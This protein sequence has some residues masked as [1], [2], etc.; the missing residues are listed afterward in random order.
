MK[1]FKWRSGYRPCPHPGSAPRRPRCP[2]PPRRPRCP[3]PRNK[4]A[5]RQP[6][7]VRFRFPARL[8]APWPREW[9]TRRVSRAPWGGRRLQRK[10]GRPWPARLANNTSMPT[11]RVDSK[12]LR[13]GQ[14]QLRQLRSAR[15][16]RSIG[17]R[18]P[19]DQL[20]CGGLQHPVF[21]SPAL[22]WL[23]TNTHTHR[24]IAELE[25]ATAN[26]HIEKQNLMEQVSLPCLRH[27]C[28]P[29]CASMRVQAQHA[30]AC[31]RTDMGR[32]LKKGLRN[33]VSGLI[34][35]GASA[36]GRGR[37]AGAG[38]GRGAMLPDSRNLQNVP[39]WQ[40]SF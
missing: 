11:L 33:P 2:R 10:S 40:Q 30:G 6:L 25:E 27:A 14:R 21:K 20:Q 19:P 34:Y 23:C 37:A 26:Q 22:L 13:I 18:L 16:S 31:E 38:P 24:M 1:R 9:G 7:F 17:E 35:N 36:G 15:T 28:W 29:A 8:P 4:P 39:T 5:L 32:N 12:R 3:R